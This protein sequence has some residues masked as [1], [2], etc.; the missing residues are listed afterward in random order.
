[1][2]DLSEVENRFSIVFLQLYDLSEVKNY[3]ET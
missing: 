1:M 3:T 2:Y